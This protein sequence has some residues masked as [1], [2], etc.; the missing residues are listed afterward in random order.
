MLHRNLKPQTEKSLITCYPISMSL[1]ATH[2][3]SLYTHYPIVA[4]G[5][6]H[7]IVVVIQPLSTL[8]RAANWSQTQ[9]VSALLTNTIPIIIV[10]TLMRY[11]KKT[12]G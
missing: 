9:R 1:S 7:L 3:F 2:D 11:Y 10:Y 12:A 5:V 4:L 8:I 6:A